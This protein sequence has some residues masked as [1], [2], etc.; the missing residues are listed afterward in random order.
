MKSVKHRTY[1]IGLSILL[2]LASACA[3]PTRV[4]YIPDGASF[5]A[6]ELTR[7]L[8]SV[9]IGDAHDIDPKD[10][11][12]ARQ[13][14]LADLRTYGDDA[15]ALAD[16]LTTD[17]PADVNAV[18]VEIWSATYEG[19]PVWVVI[20]VWGDPS[21]ELRHRRMWIYSADDVTLVSAHSIR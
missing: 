5:G 7:V 2:M 12:R 6:S 18:P 15:A 14:A 17:F 3:S 11:R 4:T 13:D 19:E 16:A 10:V 9:E 21:E 8:G 20:E 1:A